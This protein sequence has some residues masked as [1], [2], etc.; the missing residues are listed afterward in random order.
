MTKT[1]TTD[2]A[3]KTKEVVIELAGKNLTPG[4]TK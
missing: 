4:V 3:T 1:E 2:A